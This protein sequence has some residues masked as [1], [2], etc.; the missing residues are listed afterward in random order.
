[1]AD[2][3][4]SDDEIPSL[5]NL[6][7]PQ[8]PSNHGISPVV[9]VTILTGFLGSG[10][11]TL[12]QYILRSPD[13]GRKI[14]VIENEYSG[15]ATGTFLPNQMQQAG[16]PQAEKEGLSI[17]TLIA[18]DGTN[19][20]NL[21]DMIELPNGCICCTVKDSLVETLELLL[22]KKR[23]LD[24]ILIECSG[25]AN[26]GPIASIFWLDDALESR[27]RLDGI[28][29][30]VDAKN[31]G[32]ELLET[33]SSLKLYSE[34][35]KHRENG[36]GGDEAAQQIAYADRIIV[37][38]IDLLSEGIRNGEVQPIKLSDVIEEIRSIN[39]TS[40]IRTTTYS[41]IP[42]LE[43]ILDAQCFEAEKARAVEMEF[44]NTLVSLSSHSHTNSIGTLALIKKG[45]VDLKKV[46]T[47]L[48]S[49]LW[50]DQDEDDR[51]LKAQLDNLEKLDQITTDE[52]IEHRREKLLGGTMHIFRVKGILSVIHPLG[53]ED[54][55]MGLIEENGLD[56]RRY[57]V[58]AVNDLW[59]ILPAS[60]S[61]NWSSTNGVPEDRI[62]KLV[63]IGRHLNRKELLKGFKACFIR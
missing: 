7:G 31:I 1:M 19:D 52:L 35:L 58:Q 42:D 32:M 30:C 18:R 17:E 12:I 48:A 45:S 63:V 24:Y 26:P 21:T 10:K 51:V 20:S 49:I 16:G 54:E 5:L 3:F 44:T 4:S 56:K 53:Y 14:A 50:P 15:A 36:G 28:V 46:N 27:L 40:P 37:N 39:G 43:W 13:H 59:D 33:S 25:M 29:A 22:E 34:G 60:D 41:Q 9:P 6:E 62:S 61:L 38:K 11:T 47:W 55:R 8:S 23:E 2:E 57:I